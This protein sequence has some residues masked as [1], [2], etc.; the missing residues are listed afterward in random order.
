MRASMSSSASRSLASSA[1]RSRQR[2][3]ISVRF[4]SR[5]FRPKPFSSTAR[6]VSMTWAWGFGRPSVP[7]SQCTLRSAIMPW[8][9]NSACT[10]S[11][12]SSMPWRLRHLARQGELDLAG[13]LRVAPHLERLD[14]VPQ[15]LAVAPRLRC[16]VRQHDLGM[17][18]AA[19]GGEI[20]AALKP[21]VAQPR[22]RAVGGRRHRAGA[23]FAADDLDVQMIDRHRDQII[24]TAK[25]TSERRISAPSIK[26]SREGPRRPKPSR[27]PYSIPA[28]AQLSSRAINSAWRT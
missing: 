4:H 21:V 23:G 6:M 10:K 26:N 14:I 12:A 19:L 3:T 5:T 22:G 27:Q 20:V 16:I 18:D 25:R 7:M 28:G 9:T 13:E 2:S 1:Q 11:R 24:S 17:D 15:P 8:S